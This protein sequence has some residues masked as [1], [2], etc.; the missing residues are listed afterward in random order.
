MCDTVL[1]HAHT[2][3]AVR[4]VANAHLMRISESSR[5]WRISALSCVVMSHAC[6]NAQHFGSVAL[7]IELMMHKAHWLTPMQSS[8]D[9]KQSCAAHMMDVVRATEG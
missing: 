7:G 3:S 8:N 4:T 2:S 9:G 6:S 1:C 5:S